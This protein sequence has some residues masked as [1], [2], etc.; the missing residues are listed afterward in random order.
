MI[1]IDQTWPRY[2]EMKSVVAVKDA[3]QGNSLPTFGVERRHGWLAGPRPDAGTAAYAAELP[4]GCRP[5]GCCVGRAVGGVHRDRER[6]R[7]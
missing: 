3:D 2:S 4:P 5:I 1:G 7:G 6:P